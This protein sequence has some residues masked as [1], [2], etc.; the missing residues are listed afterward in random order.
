ML[1]AGRMFFMSEFSW[2][3]PTRMALRQLADQGY[4]FIVITN[5]AGLARGMLELS[6]VDEIH[7]NLVSILREE[8]GVDIIDIYMCPHH[9]D[10][11]CKCRKPR[12]GMLYQAASDHLLRLDQTIYVGDDLRDRQ[13]ANAAALAY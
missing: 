4:K 12:P 10:E 8:D 7:E 1:F 3:Q 5:Q 6:A 2:L 9:W 11:G 13:A